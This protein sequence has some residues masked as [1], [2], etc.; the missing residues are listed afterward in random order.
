[1]IPALLGL[2]APLVKPILDKI[3]NPGEREKVRMEFEAQMRSQEL[4]LLKLVMSSDLA[5]AEINKVEAASSNIFVAG[6][7][8]FVGWVCGIGFA[9]ATVLQ[10]IAVFT[11]A[12]AHHPMVTPTLQTEVLMNALFGL[13]GMG[14]LRTFEKVKGVASK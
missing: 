1:M 11:L 6:W 4:E 12:A 14:A 3:P 2:L 5:Q 8:P 9:W 7:R 13:L 10:P